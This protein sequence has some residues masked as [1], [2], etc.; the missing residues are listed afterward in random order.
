MQYENNNKSQKTTIIKL[1]GQK[2][3]EKTF[4]C[5]ENVVLWLFVWYIYGK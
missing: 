5:W 4:F 1:N 2:T 3:R